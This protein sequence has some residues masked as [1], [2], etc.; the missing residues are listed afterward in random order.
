MIKH[1]FLRVSRLT[2]K[3]ASSRVSSEAND[4]PSRAQ[5]ETASFQVS[6]VVW[7]EKHDLLPMGSLK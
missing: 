7:R 1:I 5:A 6:G 2:T 4:P 3:S